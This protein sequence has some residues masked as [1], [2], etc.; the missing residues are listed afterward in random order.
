MVP[1]GIIHK[2]LQ[3]PRGFQTQMEMQR[4]SGLSSFPFSLT[5]VSV[6]KWKTVRRQMSVRD[7]QA[8]NSLLAIA[9]LQRE[10]LKPKPPFIQVESFQDEMENQNSI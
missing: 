7:S 4:A 2:R 10:L 5:A 8:I 1:L 6:Y 9:R 3:K